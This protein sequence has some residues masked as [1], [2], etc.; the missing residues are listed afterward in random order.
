MFKRVLFFGY[1]L[2]A[3]VLFLGVAAYTVG[4]LANVPLLPKTVNSGEPASL[5]W[6]LAINIALMLAFGLHHSICARPAFK[7]WWTQYVP[8]PIERATY[9]WV[10][11]LLLAAVFA[12]WQPLPQLVWNIRQ[13]L[14]VGFVWVM[15]AFGGALILYAT[16]LIDHFEL[17]GMRQVYNYLLDRPHV[18]KKFVTPAL[19]RTIRHPLML[20]WLILFWSTPQMSVGHLLFAIVNS[21]YIFVGIALEERTLAATLGQAYVEWKQRTPMLLPW[22]RARGQNQSRRTSAKH[23]AADSAVQN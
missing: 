7:R 21:G 22:L 18:T 8:E 1:G 20:G 19:Y 10:A 9:V 5:G 11:S 4:F 2:G 12:F 6:G 16:F 17:F 14:L 3:Y 23:S 15:F 13:P